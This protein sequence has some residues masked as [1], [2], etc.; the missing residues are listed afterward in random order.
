MVARDRRR[1]WPNPFSIAVVHPDGP[2]LLRSRK[3][4]SREYVCREISIGEAPQ[5]PRRCFRAERHDLRPPQHV[6]ELRLRLL[7]LHAF[8][9]R[10]GRLT[11]ARDVP[12]AA[13]VTEA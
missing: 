5:S 13:Y 12:E 6:R 10:T 4:T 3:R 2:Q 8:R 1:P 9:P 7:L 11:C